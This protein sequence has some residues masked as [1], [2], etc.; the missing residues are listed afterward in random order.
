MLY[1]DVTFD[2]NTIHDALLNKLQRFVV[3]AMPYWK[4]G[5][6]PKGAI[7]SFSGYL[8]DCPKGW[9]VCDGNNGTPD[10]TGSFIP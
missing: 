5:G 8:S 9:A 10:L 6:M 1:P 7:I 4:L 3:S 2:P